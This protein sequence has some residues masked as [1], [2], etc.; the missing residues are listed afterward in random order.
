MTFHGRRRPH[1]HRAPAT[2]TLPAQHGPRPEPNPWRRRPSPGQPQIAWPIP[3]DGTVLVGVVNCTPDSFSDGGQHPDAASAV[4]HAIDL[5]ADGAH[6]ID[7]GGESTRP[8]AAPV[9]PREEQHRV[10]PVVAALAELRIPVSID[11]MHASTAR[12][13]VAVGANVVNDV[14]GGLADPAMLPTLARLDCQVVLGHLRGT[15]ATMTGLADY[16]DAAQ[17]VTRE[18]RERAETAVATGITANRIVLDPG[19]GFAKTPRHNWAILRSLPS[20]RALGYPIMV[21]VS[22]KRFLA[23]LLPEAAPV[24]DRDL[25]TAVLTALLAQTG[26]NALRVHDVAASA[27]A[28]RTVRAL[29]D[30]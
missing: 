23:V 7:I 2:G 13:A 25:P 18:L 24:I 22:R 30:V 1:T 26:A 28:L 9:D 5:R 6:L 20:L 21:G 19:I 27:A 29:S 12:A 16:G 14:S 8:G 15:P 17:E 3:A 11:T 4:A 10:L